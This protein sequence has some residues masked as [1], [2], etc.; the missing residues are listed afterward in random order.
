MEIELS[1]ENLQFTKQMKRKAGN[2][3]EYLK[4]L[5][6]LKKGKIYFGSE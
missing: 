4:K 2:I 6:D 3:C 1:I 5:E